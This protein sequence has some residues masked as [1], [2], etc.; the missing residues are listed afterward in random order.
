[1]DKI[2]YYKT[3]KITVTRP[4]NREEINTLE[5][6]SIDGYTISPTFNKNTKEYNVTLINNDKYLQVAA[7]E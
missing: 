6:L 5:S 1:M 4:D 3:Y 7:A 2:Q